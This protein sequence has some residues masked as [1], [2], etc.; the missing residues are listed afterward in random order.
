MMT[1]QATG[2]QILPKEA[3]QKLGKLNQLVESA[4]AGDVEVIFITLPMRAE[5]RIRELIRELA[6]STVSV[7]IV[8]DLFVFQMLHSRWSDVQGVP[9]VSVFENPFYGVDGILKRTVD[10]VLVIDCP[11]AGCSHSDGHHR[12][13]R[14]T[15]IPGSNPVSPVA[16]RIGRKRNPRLEIPQHDG[17]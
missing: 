1:D 5:D 12:F 9:V 8:P 6:D 16:I 14:K 17:L 15:D 3:D 7:Y 2:R 10:L 4:K 11:G 13:G